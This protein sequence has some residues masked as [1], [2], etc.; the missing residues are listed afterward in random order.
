MLFGAAAPRTLPCSP[1]AA[2]AEAE[3][4]AEDVV[5]VVAVVT[6]EA[7][8]AAADD[9]VVDGDAAAVEEDATVVVGE[10]TAA[11]SWASCPSE[12]LVV[13]ASPPPDATPDDG[14]EGAAAAVEPAVVDATPTEDSGPGVEGSPGPPVEPED[15]LASAAG[16]SPGAD[17][18]I[19]AGE[20]PRADRLAPGSGCAPVAG[21][22]DEDEDAALAAPAADPD[23]GP[24]DVA[25]L[26]EPTAPAPH[27]AT[28]DSLSRLERRATACSLSFASALRCCC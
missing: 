20:P 10:D 15:P 28:C 19:D 16:F 24:V 8:A 17:P 1:A 22:P 25:A 12:P 21:P 13:R 6:V 2:S 14:P 7:A 11:P 27:A 26:A 3:G 18:G 4:D 23:E 5:A 9:A